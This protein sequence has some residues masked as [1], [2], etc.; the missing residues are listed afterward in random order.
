MQIIQKLKD[1]KNGYILYS[2]VMFFL[3]LW[4]SE[5]IGFDAK[6]A[7]FNAVRIGSLL[8]LVTL[9]GSYLTQSSS[10]SFS[11]GK[12]R[13]LIVSV[14]PLSLS[15]GVYLSF[16]HFP[17]FS[18]FFKTLSL[19]GVAILF[20]LINLVNNIFLVVD[21]KEIVFPLYRVA[22]TWSQILLVIVSIPVYVGIYKFDQGPIYQALWAGAATFVLSA[23][24]LWSLGFDNRI[25]RTGILEK[26]IN[27]SFCAFLV[28][29]GGLAVSF[30][31]T[32][33]FLRGLFS[34]SILLF[35]L[36]YL[37]GYLKNKL[38]SSFLYIYG[39]IFGIFLFLILVFRP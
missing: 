11:R 20:Y 34:A 24:Y 12:F 8:F 36:N 33:A 25:R 28:M 4:L 19:V 31:P 37:D 38:N 22:V 23:Y 35:G 15:L 2:L 32:E 30:I 5:S 18:F 14:L 3:F 16:Y 1:K 13:G 7:R 26:V 17:N 39:T 6:S 10:L 29:V 21:E 27:C 9:A